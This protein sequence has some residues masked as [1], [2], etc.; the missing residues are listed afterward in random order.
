MTVT[1]KELSCLTAF[2]GVKLRSTRKTHQSLT[3]L[4]N[5]PIKWQ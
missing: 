5:Q 1:Q 2:N 3:Q 4:A